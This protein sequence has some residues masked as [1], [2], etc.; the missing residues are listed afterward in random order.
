MAEENLVQPVAA[1][2]G[3]HAIPA[4]RFLSCVSPICVTKLRP[5]SVQMAQ[6]GEEP[7]GAESTPAWAGLLY[8]A[9]RLTGWRLHRPVNAS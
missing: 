3:Q 6:S 9:V 2:K 1:G 8:S 4:Q 5:K 7:E